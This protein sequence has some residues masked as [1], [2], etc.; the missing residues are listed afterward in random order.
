MNYA[1]KPRVIAKSANYTVNPARPDAPGTVFTNRGATAPVTF[2]LPVPNA[3]LA[4][5]GFQFRG[6]ADQN[7]IVS[8]GAGKGIAFNNAACASLAFQTAGQR[9]G[10]SINALCDGASWLL[11]GENAGVTYTIA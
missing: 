11:T 9:I 10:A 8:A 4:G 3:G 6:V 5:V 1:Y 7:V 2:T